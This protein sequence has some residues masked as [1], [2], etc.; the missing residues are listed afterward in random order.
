MSVACFEEHSTDK[1]KR[2]PN[3]PAWASM[4]E[5]ATAMPT[6]RPSSF[7]A[8]GVSPLPREAPGGSTWFP[9]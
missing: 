9:G 2:L 4:S 1:G 8:S 5:A 6:G 3:P 7:A